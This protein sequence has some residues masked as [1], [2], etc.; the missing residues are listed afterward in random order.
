MAQKL[1][2][3]QA[4]AAKARAAY[5]QKRSDA[6]QARQMRVQQLQALFKDIQV[7]SDAITEELMRAAP[8]VQDLRSE[9][10]M[11]LMSLRYLREIA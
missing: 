3:K 4:Q 6:E 1:K 11:L 10:R 2:A 8:E 5:A 7:H 9:F